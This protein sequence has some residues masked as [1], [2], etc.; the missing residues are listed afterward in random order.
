M[1]KCKI[2]GKEFN[3]IY[4]VMRHVSRLHKVN[5]EEYYNKFLR[6]DENEGKC[7]T[8]GKPTKFYNTTTGYSKFCCTKCAMSNEL[9]KNKIADTI[10][11]HYG[12]RCPFQSE[13]VKEKIKQTNLDRY[14]VERPLQNTEIRNKVDKT[15]L[16]RYGKTTALILDDSLEKSHSKKAVEKCYN[17]KKKNNTFSSSKPEK[18]LEIKLKEMFP[19]LETHY[20]SKKYPF[21][22][23]FY[24]PSLE[25][26]IECNF[27]WSHGFHFFDCNNKQ[28]IDKLNML[29]EKSK[30]SKY[31]K[32]AVNTWSIRDVLKLETA[33]KNNLNY[34]AWFTPQ[35]AYDWI[36][37][38]RVG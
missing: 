4:S 6:K 30:T 12:V 31:Y 9:T 25:L 35:Q 13:E 23:D 10:M 29:K 37:K 17:T 2:C 32:I 5:K 20:K 3:S 1:E 27:H 33:I 36:E 26:Y 24:I 38:Y 19:D 8:C 15:N 21:N 18:E 16:E 22:C 7:L 11:S 14:G 34:I 28:D